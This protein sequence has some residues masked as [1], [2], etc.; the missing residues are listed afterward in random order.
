MPP[1][2]IDIQQVASLVESDPTLTAA[3]L[4]TANSAYFGA[5]REI[6]TVLQAMTRMGLED[7]LHILSYHCLRGMMPTPKNLTNFSAKEFWQHSWAT[8]TAARMLGAPQYLVHARPGELYTAGLLHD[9]GK[10]VLAVHL[11]EAFDLACGMAREQSLPIHKAEMELMGLDHAKLGG[12][13]LDGWNLPQPILE[14][15][16]HHHDPLAAEAEMQEIAA[17]IELADAIAF[18]CGYADGTGQPALD[19]TQT[20]ITGFPRSPLAAAGAID[21]LIETVSFKLSEKEQIFNRRKQA[22]HRDR[23]FMPAGQR[24]ATRGGVHAADRIENPA[25]IGKRLTGW[26]RGFF[27]A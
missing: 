19:P 24:V 1:A 14:G 11:G 21:R 9:I 15:V 17:L 4:R 12:H 25:G 7:T 13:V 18:H 20:A 6:T 8:A 22:A 27:G 3:L 23:E 10:I 26:V 16:R 2:Q 5:L